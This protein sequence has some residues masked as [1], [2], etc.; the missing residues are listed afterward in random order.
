MTK[1]CTRCGEVKPRS[2][3]HHCKRATTGLRCACKKCESLASAAWTKRHRA[4]ATEHQRR[5]WMERRALSL[6]CSAKAR[7]TKRGLMFDL[8]FHTSAI[9]ARIDSGRCELSGIP[10]RLTGGR[11]FDSPSIDRINPA[12]GYIYTN[13]R[14]VCSCMNAALGDWGEEILH[15]VL[16]SWNQQRARRGVAAS[17]DQAPALAPRRFRVV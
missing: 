7:A 1:K 2:D 13:I 8:S 3:F 12:I 16:T 10:F 6:V 9:Q 14:I 15:A 5:Y 4:R 17:D 11:T